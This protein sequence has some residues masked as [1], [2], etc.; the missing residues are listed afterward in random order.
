MDKQVRS[1]DNHY[2][3]YG[4]E[5]QT[6]MWLMSH[7]LSFTEKIKGCEIMFPDTAFFKNGEARV[8][9]KTDNDSYCLTSVKK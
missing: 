7:L 4:G 5:P 9:I 6:F 3:N 2:L 8:I 1:R